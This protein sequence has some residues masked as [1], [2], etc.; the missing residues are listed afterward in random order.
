MK[1][2]MDEKINEETQEKQ[3]RKDEGSGDGCI[4]LNGQG[5]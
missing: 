5:S 3:G 2:K 1:R 4:Y